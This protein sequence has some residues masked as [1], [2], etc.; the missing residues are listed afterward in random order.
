MATSSPT[1]PATQ[2]SQSEVD[3][4]TNL[5]ATHSPLI[6]L[7]R[8]LRDLVLNFVFNF[9]FTDLLVDTL[10]KQARFPIYNDY[11][12]AKQLYTT[13]SL[14]ILFRTC[15]QILD[16]THLL[17]FQLCEFYFDSWEA[18]HTMIR[19]F[20]SEQQQAIRRIRLCVS[21]AFNMWMVVDSGLGILK[22]YVAF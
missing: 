19:K 7:P 11:T 22:G 1:R 20:T 12:W 9:V 2:L 14:N 10:P 6:R 15:R 16:E 21:M 17:P 13:D 18:L 4:L 5:N 8:E 3:T